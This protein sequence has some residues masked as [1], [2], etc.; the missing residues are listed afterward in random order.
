MLLLCRVYTME[1][2][3]CI[4]SFSLSFLYLR[5]ILLTRSVVR[6][7]VVSPVN[8]FVFTPMLASASVGTIEYRSS[9]LILGCFTFRMF[10]HP[11][12]LTILFSCFVPSPD[13]Q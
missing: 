9:E 1:Y 12:F 7:V 3:F 8:H 2:L 13:V 6:I 10:L 11:Y 4:T 5:A